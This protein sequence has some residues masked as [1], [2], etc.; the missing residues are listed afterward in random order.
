MKVTNKASFDII[1]FGVHVPKGYG[2]DVTIPPGETAEISGPY[3][4]EMGDGSCYIHLDGEVTCQEEPDDDNGLQIGRGNPICLQGGNRGVTIRHYADEP[5]AHVTAWRKSNPLRA[6]TK[7]I[8]PR[9]DNLADLEG[10]MF[11]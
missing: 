3:V 2:D 4:G 7:T 8:R 10:M 1:A 11:D 9:G 6:P 5:E